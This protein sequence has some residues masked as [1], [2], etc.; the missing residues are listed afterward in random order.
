MMNRLVIFLCI[1]IVF[2]PIPA[3]AEKEIYINLWHRTLQLQENGKVLKTYRIGVGTR[4]TPSPM[5]VFKIIDKA[6]NWYDGFGPR[7]MQLSVPW[8]AF[9]IHGTD[10]P[11]S[12]G[13]YV[14]EGCIRMYDHQV[15]E[16]YKLVPMG[17]KVTID[18]PLTGHPDVPYRLLVNGS[19]G[20]LVKMVQHYLQGAGYYKGTCNGIFNRST[21]IAVTRYQKDH[22]LPVTAQ[23]DYDDFIYM[24]IFE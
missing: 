18:G 24:G 17:T 2:F 14:S 15:I 12:I 13:G 10:E 19:R 22:H 16:L 8:G 4:D 5:G 21:E 23:I 20:A 11:H 9:G 7:W 6:E 1:A 3:Y